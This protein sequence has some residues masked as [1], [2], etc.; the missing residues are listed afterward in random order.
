MTPVVIFGCGDLAQVAK[1][2]LNADSPYRVV[3]FTA[4]AEHCRESSIL[5]CPVVPFD[6]LTR[7][8]PP[9]DVRMLVAVGY[10]RVNKN[11]AAI[12]ERCKRLGYSLITYVSSRAMLMDVASVGD[13][14]VILE[15]T[16]I[17]PFAVIGANV[18][19]SAGV[20][21]GHHAVIEDHCFMASHVAV[22]GRARIKRNS[23]LGVNAT[24]VDRVTVGVENII[25]AGALIKRDTG[26]REVYRAAATPAAA[27]SSARLWK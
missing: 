17:Q 7:H 12:Y 20:R 2:Y 6:A 25:G 8:Y 15:G 19:L 11:R 13:N 26:D 3:A 10:S 24:V 27:V 21:I 14:C 16:M 5:D 22:A 1:C 23:F 4:D 18:V 9:A